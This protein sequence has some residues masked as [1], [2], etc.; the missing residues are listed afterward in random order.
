[1]AARADLQPTDHVPAITRKLEPFQLE[2]T[3]WALEQIR[4]HTASQGAQT[5]I[6]LVPTPVDPEIVAEEFD[7]I[8]PAIH[9]AGLPV[10]DLRDAF[11]SSS[12]HLGALQVDPGLDNHPNARAHELLFEELYQKILQDPKLSARVL[13]SAWQENH[14]SR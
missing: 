4:D 8:R 10:I 13:G 6:V 14:V 3:R 5:V 2:V 12:R 11:R 7:E 9:G 1:V